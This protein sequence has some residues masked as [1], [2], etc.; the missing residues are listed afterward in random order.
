M[1]RIRTRTTDAAAAAK[2]KEQTNKTENVYAEKN[3]HRLFTS[4]SAVYSSG[5][6]VIIM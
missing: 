6:C 2:K 5:K 4:Y 1:V 3:N